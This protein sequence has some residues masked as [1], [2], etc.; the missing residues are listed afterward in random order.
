MSTRTPP[1]RPQYL[2]VVELCEQRQ[3]GDRAHLQLLSARLTELDVAD[4]FHPVV[5]SD[6]KSDRAREPRALMGVGPAL[7]VDQGRQAQNA[8]TAA[9]VHRPAN[10]RLPVSCR[11]DRERPRVGL[12]RRGPRD[13]HDHGQHTSC[14]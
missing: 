13:R 7:L 12:R 2:V 1:F 9:L 8:S 5:Q 6:A 10:A 4:R 11:R 14:R 3:R